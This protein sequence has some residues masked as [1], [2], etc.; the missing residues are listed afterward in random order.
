MKFLKLDLRTS[1]FSKNFRTS[2][3]GVA[4]GLIAISQISSLNCSWLQVFP[5]WKAVPLMRKM[6]GC[7]GSVLFL[8]MLVYALYFIVYLVRDQEL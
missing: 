1:C 2:A 6:C 5:Y 7:I 8:K 4:I 3:A